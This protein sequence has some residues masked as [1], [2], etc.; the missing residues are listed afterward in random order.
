MVNKALS[1][2]TSGVHALNPITSGILAVR[3]AHQAHLHQVMSS[4]SAVREVDPH[5]AHDEV[6]LLAEMGYKQELR[7]HYTT[8]EAFGIAFSI[9]GLL[10]SIAS[11]IT[12]G[13][14]MGPAG[15]V[16]AWFIA[17]GF[18]LCIGMSLTIM[19]SALPTSGGLYYWTNYYAPE[20]CRVPLSFLIGCSNTIALCSG[21][22]S[23]AYGFGVEVLSAVYINRDGDFDITNGKLYGMFC[24]SVIGA[25]VFCCLTTKHGAWLQT[26]S[27]TINSFLIVLFFIAVP[28]G[29]K[30]NIGKFN[31]ANFIFSKMPNARTWTDFWSFCLSMMPAIWTIGAFDSVIH[32][33]EEL[34]SKKSIPWGILGSITVCWIVGWFIVITFV[35]CIKDGDIDAILTTDTGSGMAQV[36]YDSLGKEWCVA[37]MSLIASGQ[38]LMG[39]SIALAASRQIWAFARDD[40]TPFIY[41]IIKYVNPKVAVPI[42]ATIFAAILSCI[43]GLL[44]L[45]N[46]TAANALF[47]LYIASNLLAWGLPVFLV[48]LPYGKSRFNPGPFWFGQTASTC[49]HVTTVLWIVFV[50]ILCMFPDSTLVDKN[51]MNYTVAINV[52]VWSLA[53]LYYYFYGYKVYSGPKSN[54]SGD[55][56]VSSDV[57]VE[58]IDAVMEQKA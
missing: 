10:P 20:W 21:L 16:W 58:K 13:L 39:C 30:K 38:F 9:M 41:K 40:G 2:V 22:C 56:P 15:F 54:L 14:E 28:I 50:I 55:T 1:P 53:M 36:I 44:V 31:D 4:K 27:V 37:F 19:A 49:I 29:T 43:I 32:M 6:E 12:S 8:F 24:V 17:G 45:I 48:L 7:R 18:T 33:S 57:E 11:T 46:T 34:K 42:N 52:P 25:C 5:A 26:A 51:T 35:A 3:S 47:S 23:I